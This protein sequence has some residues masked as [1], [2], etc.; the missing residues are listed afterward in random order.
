MKN[1][2][3]SN[4]AA[5]F[6]ET[7]K[8]LSIVEFAESSLGLKLKLFPAQK[9]YL[10]LL[11]GE[12]LDG[13]TKTIQLKDKFGEKV[14]K[15]LTEVEYYEYLLSEKKVNCTYEDLL[16]N[17]SNIISYIFCSMYLYDVYRKY[18]IVEADRSSGTGPPRGG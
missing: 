5:S 15:E 9:F 10:K 17:Y 14:L 18:C 16:D 8:K 6:L 1:E 12:L 2:S 4:Y 7:T 11:A 3:L 13:I